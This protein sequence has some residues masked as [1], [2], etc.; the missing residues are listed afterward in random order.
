MV[1]YTFVLL[2]LAVFSILRLKLD[3]I[4]ANRHFASYFKLSLILDRKFRLHDE[5]RRAKLR[6]QNVI[7][8]AEKGDEMFQVHD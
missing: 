1:S 5:E 6:A 3:S 2:M 7:Y 4:P 8:I